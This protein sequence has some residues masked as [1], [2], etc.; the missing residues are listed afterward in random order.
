MKDNWYEPP[1]CE[2][3]YIEWKYYCLLWKDCVLTPAGYWI[4]AWLLRE[5]VESLDQAI[6]YYEKY[7]Q[8]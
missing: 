2:E 1:K 5:P 3:E 4:R 8:S 7:N 6:C